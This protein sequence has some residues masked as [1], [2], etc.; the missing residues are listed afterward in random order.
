MK[1][2]NFFPEVYNEDWLFF[3]DDV[4]SKELGWSGRNA[5]QLYYNPFEPQRRAEWQ[6]FG[7]VL[8]EGLYALLVQGLGAD[9]ATCEYWNEFLL[10]RR[11]FIEILERSN[12]LTSHIQAEMVGA[13]Q[14]AMLC[15]IQIKPVMYEKYVKA[16]RKDIRIW[17]ENV[18]CLPRYTSVESALDE[19]QLT[20]IID[21]AKNSYNS[22]AASLLLCV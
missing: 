13:M 3:Y 8:A 10:A 12:D 17:S 2:F 19:L 21:T 11:Y 5:T 6:E 22:G 9:A 7:D 20:W 18:P 15:L 1:P 16:W 4:R 14:T